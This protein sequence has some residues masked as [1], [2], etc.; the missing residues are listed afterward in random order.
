MQLGIVV[1]IER[2]W[3]RWWYSEEADERVEVSVVVPRR[4]GIG[5]GGGTERR[6]MVEN[7]EHARQDGEE[8][9]IG[10]ECKCK[11]VRSTCV[12]VHENG[13]LRFIAELPFS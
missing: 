10:T 5:G 9:A 8:R 4:R 2:W 11:V 6:R 13:K 1:C 7:R 3:W 12:H